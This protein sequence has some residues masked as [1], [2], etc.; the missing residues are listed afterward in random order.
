MKSAGKARNN[1]LY[2]HIRTSKEI[3]R[4]LLNDFLNF[5][6]PLFFSSID[7][8]LLL[9]PFFYRKGL[10]I[11]II[12][13][14]AAICKSKAAPFIENK[15]YPLTRKN[16]PGKS[17]DFPGSS[18][19]KIIFRRFMCYKDAYAAGCSAAA[20]CGSAVTVMV[21]LMVLQE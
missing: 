12:A 21:R 11:F 2:R 18:N 3:I 7:K 10:F 16:D 1:G 20:G 6:M 8:L 17:A 5:L 14:C 13:Y 19:S 9:L 4:N 15:K